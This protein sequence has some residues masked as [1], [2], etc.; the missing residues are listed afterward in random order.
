MSFRFDCSNKPEI[1]SK[2]R[3]IAWITG[4][5]W[6]SDRLGE[7][8]EWMRPFSKSNTDQVYSKYLEITLKIT[9][10]F[11]YLWVWLI[12]ICGFSRF[13][14]VQFRIEFVLGLKRIAR[15]RWTI[16]S[17]SK[18]LGPRCTIQ[19]YWHPSWTVGEQMLTSKNKKTRTILGM[20][21]KQCQ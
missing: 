8:S 19:A 1:G 15:E 3:K 20:F 16:Q 21:F 5:V 14:S 18:N 2:L 17:T 11:N 13:Q 12:K 10:I 9:C 6:R 7:R 4:I